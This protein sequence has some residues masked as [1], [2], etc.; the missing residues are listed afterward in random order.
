MH[1]D[2]APS[3][4]ARLMPQGSIVLRR[5]K[6]V[7]SAAERRATGLPSSLD[8]AA[9]LYAGEQMQHLLVSTIDLGLV[10][11]HAQWNAHGRGSDTLRQLFDDLG[12]ALSGQRDVLARRAAELGVPPDGRART[13]AAESRLPE[14]GEGPFRA[15]D[16]AA[17][18]AERLDRV[19]EMT[20]RELGVLSASDQATRD[21]VTRLAQLIERHHRW[22]LQR[23]GVPG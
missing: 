12:K 18:I 16:A 21:A 5:G 10:V 20:R 19:A 11:D 6:R 23:T 14:L 3:P 17:A 7:G 8:A 13:V 2:R 4:R 9:R 15:I 1:P 22:I